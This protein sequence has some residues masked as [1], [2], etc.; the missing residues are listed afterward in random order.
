MFDDISDSIDYQEH[1]H[2]LLVETLCELQSNNLQAKHE[3]QRQSRIILEH[4]EELKTFRLKYNEAKSALLSQVEATCRRE[5]EQKE[6]EMKWKMFLERE[7]SEY[8]NNNQKLTEQSKQ[9]EDLRKQIQNEIEQ[10]YKDK[11]EYIEKEVS[12]CYFTVMN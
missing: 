11:I 6:I 5:N 1:D 10:K 3:L 9:L 2:T 7:R 12:T 8:F 4:E